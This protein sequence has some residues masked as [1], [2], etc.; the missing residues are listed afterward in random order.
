MN[1]STVRLKKTLRKYRLLSSVLG[2]LVLILALAAWRQ[3]TEVR[4]ERVVLLSSDGTPSLILVAGEKGPDA[5]LVIQDGNGREVMRL[6][7]PHVRLIG[8]G[9]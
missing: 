7:G 1:E 6:G 4:A 8:G 2:L 3:E 5:A 9:E